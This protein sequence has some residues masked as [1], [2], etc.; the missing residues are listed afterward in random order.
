MPAIIVCYFGSIKCRQPV[1]L[2]ATFLAAL[3]NWVATCRLN[4]HINVRLHQ[5]SDL[6]GCMFKLP[7]WGKSAAP[8]LDA[9]THGR[10]Y[11]GMLY[12]GTSFSHLP[13]IC[14]AA[15]LLRCAI[16]TRG[17]CAIWTGESP[18]RALMYAPPVMLGGKKI[19]C[20]VAV[21][22]LRVKGSHFKSHD[23]QLI[24]RECWHQLQWLMLFEYQ[25]QELYRK[26]VGP[27]SNFLPAFEWVPSYSNWD[28][29]P[30]PWVVANNDSTNGVVEAGV[31]AIPLP[32]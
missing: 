11:D 9:S 23:K 31:P 8:D 3:D 13:S 28:P 32:R 18:S 6:E 2:E 26:H 29:L 1:N 12:H 16:P 24:V 22:A 27:L 21:H 14:S 17:K 7:L 25:G 20:V 30:P 10:P 5:P 4:T 19:Q 15:C